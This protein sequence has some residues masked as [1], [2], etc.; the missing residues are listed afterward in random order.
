MAGV[1]RALDLLSCNSLGVDHPR[2]ALSELAGEQHPFADQSPHR[3]LVPVEGR[4]RLVQRQLAAL[5]PF[6]RLIP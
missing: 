2:G 5:R 3:R 6:A 1:G 4:G